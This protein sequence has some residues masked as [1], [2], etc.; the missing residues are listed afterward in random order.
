MKAGEDS[1]EEIE[2]FENSSDGCRDFSG[3]SVSEFSNT[4]NARDCLGRFPGSEMMDVVKNFPRQ[5]RRFGNPTTLNAVSV[6]SVFAKNNG[7]KMM[8]NFVIFR[9]Q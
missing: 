5:M 7:G 2:F 6:D 9:T 1:W 3:D 4:A 8:R